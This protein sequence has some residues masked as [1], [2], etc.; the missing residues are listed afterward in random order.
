M[1][2]D[3]DELRTLYSD[4]YETPVH[5]WRLGPRLDPERVSLL[6][7]VVP[8]KLVGIGRSYGEHARELGNPVPGEPVLFLKATS[9]VI[10]PRCPIVLPPE[11]AQ[12]EY[13]GEIAV[14][15]GRRLRRASG[16]E[17]TSAVLGVT[18]ACDVT[19]RDLQRRDPC[20]AR[21]KSFDTFCPLGPAVW[22]GA[23]LDELT[24]ETRVNGQRRQ[25]GATSQMLWPLPEMLAYASR[26]MTLD[27]GDVVLTGTPAGV[28]P[29]ADGDTVE[30]E[31]SGVGTI[32]NPVECWRQAPA[33]ASR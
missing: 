2:V 18:A 25:H 16:A 9:S 15:I 26:M 32:V 23:P 20:F 29:L 6:A 5:A 8:G 13:E 30:V 7:P 24:V 27:P 17:V 12:V 10:G 21:A 11:S 28:G 1:F 22:V 3:D 19:A 33:E 4:P 31:V 14:V